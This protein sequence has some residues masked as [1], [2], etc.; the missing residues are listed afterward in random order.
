M[1]EYCDEYSYI[2]L[3]IFSSLQDDNNNNC[4]VNTIEIEKTEIILPKLF[5]LL[6]SLFNAG[7]HLLDQALGTTVLRSDVIMT[8]VE[9]LPAGEV[10]V[11]VLHVGSGRGRGG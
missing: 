7:R 6:S 11:I 10:L 3:Q 2:R 8:A 9:P 1:K 5:F 4:K